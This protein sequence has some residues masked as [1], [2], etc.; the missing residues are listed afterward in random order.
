MSGAVKKNTKTVYV[1]QA[2]GYQTPKW[3]GK[4][5]DC[6][7]WETLLEERLQPAAGGRAPRVVSGKKPVLIDSGIPDHEKRLGTGIR[8]FDRVLGGGLVPGTVVLIGGDPGIG[9]STL[10]LQ[11]LSGMASLKKKT[12]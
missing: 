6:G 12:L 8:E 7:Q 5:P 3:M 4:C 1:C 11:A 9:K 10:M 2:C